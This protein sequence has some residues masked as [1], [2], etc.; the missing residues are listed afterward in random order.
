VWRGWT[1]RLQFYRR[2]ERD[3][4]FESQR[5]VIVND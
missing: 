1:E 5:S 3:D 4:G 2:S